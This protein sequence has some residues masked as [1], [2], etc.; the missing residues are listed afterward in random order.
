MTMSSSTRKF[1]Y[2]KNDDWQCD[3]S[4]THNSKRE[5]WSG[6]GWYRVT[7]GAGTQLSSHAFTNRTDGYCKTDVGGWITGGNLQS[8]TPGQIVSR[9][10][11][12]DRP[13]YDSPGANFD[14]SVTNCDGFFVYDLPD[15]G[16][17]SFRYCTQ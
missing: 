15:I 9:T 6:P 14:I 16:G 10:I 12:F 7:G 13:G 17:C 8:T 3:A 11:R 2:V 1:D 5:D 4:Y